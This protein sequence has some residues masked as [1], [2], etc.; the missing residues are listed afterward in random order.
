MN[1]LLQNLRYAARMLWKNRGFTA[2]AVITLALGIG[3]N[4]AVFSTVNALLLHPQPFPNLERLM[5][6]REGRASQG[7]DEKRFSIADFNDLRN[8]TH[9]FE[10]L[11]GFRYGEFNLTGGEH[12]EGA[13]GAAVSTNFFRL[14][15]AGAAIGR[16]FNPD[17]G[18]PGRDQVMMVSH[19]YWVTRFGSDPNLVGRTLH[20]NG[21]ACAVI[22]VMPEAYN[23][24][25]GIDVWVPLVLRPEERAD[26]SQQVLHVLGR[27]RPAISLAQAQ[28]EMQGFGVQLARQY[29]DTDSG[30]SVTLLPLREEQ[31]QYT[32]PMFLTLQAAAGFVL[33]LACANL[34]SLL[35]ARLLARQREIAI[36]T[37]LGAD[38]KRVAAIFLT[39][40]ILLSLLAGI[41]AVAVSFWSVTLIRT[42]V[43][44]G[45]TKWIAGWGD[46]RVN[47][48]V[49]GF[50]IL[51]AG[52]VG[53]VF[54]MMTALRASS[55]DPNQTLKEGS[56]GA[57]AS[58]GK[59]RWRS[60]LVVSQ[61]ALA[62]V[63]LV[64][65]GL[66]IKGFMHLVTVY[67]GL[68][69]SHVATL[70]I[71]LP[72]KT[73]P[74]DTRIASFYQRF[75]SSAAA[76][77]GVET[78]GIADNIPASNVD[79]STTQFTIETRPALKESEIPAAGFESISA[80]FLRSLRIP[81]LQGRGL[82]DEDGRDRM[83]VAVIS[84]AMATRFWPRESPLG[85]RIK[86][87]GPKSNAPWATIV[88]IVGDVKQNWWDPQPQPTIYLPYQQAPQ[89]N[90]NVVAR[91]FSEP[92]GLIAAMRAQ[93]QSIDPE[94][95]FND[96]QSMEGVVADSLS[97]LR[98]LGILMVVF[99]GVAL[100]LSAVGVYG[101]LAQSVAQ[102]T[103]EF[104]IRMALG[105]KPHDVLKH[106]LGQAVR[107]SGIG[108]ALALPLSLVL[109][110][111]MGSLLYGIVALNIGILGGLTGTLILVAL[112]AGYIPA[113]RA[114][115]VDPMV[116]LRY[117]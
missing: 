43:P 115:K 62:M 53:S 61:V 112:A 80:D 90:M 60:G 7:E 108:L 25:L 28:S 1:T 94:V 47:A 79:N 104:G 34:A 54:G 100:A 30:K 48:W 103:R 52:L 20:L 105:A 93:V 88:G 89:R 58:P 41:V 65:A 42:S 97:P 22:G 51:L 17:D 38:W 3:A 11:A 5:L 84:Q 10:E 111:A 86:L 14:L 2:I 56:G 13:E 26:R 46:I 37:A 33:L 44:V 75:L 9:A 35:F 45:I 116:A 87:G 39:E 117:E 29:P 55:L 57:S 24:P 40:N 16:T 91:T 21:R 82:S 85:Q 19:R 98:I 69:I 66:M 59:N 70:R 12:A 8:Q 78:V 72:D 18:Q 6:I 68:E 109:T 99:G 92:M 74:D 95:P 31:Y 49:L 73:Y 4:V 64:G 81:L 110:R 71:A 27:L 63:L 83:R 107:L 96:V 23:Y 32:A 77:P 15:G 102:R 113:R 67:Q 50:A 114:A 106:V 36:R 76:L 101:V